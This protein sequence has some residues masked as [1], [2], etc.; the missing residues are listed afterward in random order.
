MAATGRYFAHISN[1]FATYLP[2]GGIGSAQS[3]WSRNP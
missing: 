1:G 2:A 3:R